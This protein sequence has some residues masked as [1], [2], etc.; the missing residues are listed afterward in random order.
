MRVL[1]ADDSED[2]CEVVKIALEPA[3]WQVRTCR[4][5]AEALDLVHIF[6][7]DVVL[8]DVRMPVLDGP[9]TL[10]RLR[11]DPRTRALPV[12]FMTG[13]GRTDVLSKLQA[14]NPAGLLS[15]PFLPSELQGLIEA[16]M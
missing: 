16:C 12:I 11:L 15:K 13:V 9:A 6:E 5:G 8:L 10:E 14:M 4:N 2:I 1:F 3:G 7:P